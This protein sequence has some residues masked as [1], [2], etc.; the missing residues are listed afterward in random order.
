[1]VSITQFQRLI[2]FLQWEVGVGSEGLN[3]DMYANHIKDNPECS[4]GARREDAYHY[5]L[6]CPN[7][8]NPRRILLDGRATLT[9]KDILY[10]S[11]D[12]TCEENCHLVN[13]VHNFIKSS[14]RFDR[15]P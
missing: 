7:F 6:Q 15:P 12:S 11:A 8:T 5:F 3:A 1:M 14:K 13:K 10:G 9:I 2:F 4:C